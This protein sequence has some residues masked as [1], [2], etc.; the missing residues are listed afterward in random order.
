MWAAGPGLESRLPHCVSF[1]TWIVGAGFDPIADRTIR[2]VQDPSHLGRR[3]S[4]APHLNSLSRPPAITAC[5]A[6]GAS[7]LL[8]ELSVRTQLLPV[9]L[10]PRLCF[11]V[12]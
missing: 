2:F 10:G 11:G 1:D 9:V 12:Q 5:S 6:P 8:L 4:S 3:R 7:A